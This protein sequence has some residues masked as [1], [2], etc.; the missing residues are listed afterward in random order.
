MTIYSVKYN[1]DWR[2]RKWYNEYKSGIRIHD[3]FSIMINQFPILVV[4]K[5]D[6]PHDSVDWINY[7]VGLIGLT[8]SK[9]ILIK[10]NNDET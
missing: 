4:R 6:D 10:R 2:P 3:Y 1:F 7:S 9:Y 8:F 5:Y